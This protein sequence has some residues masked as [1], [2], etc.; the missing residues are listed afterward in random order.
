MVARW[1]PS[2]LCLVC[3]LLPP[4]LWS[5]WVPSSAKIWP[6]LAGPEKV[7]SKWYPA[8]LL[9]SPQESAERKMFLEQ[10]KRFGCSL[11]LGFC[12][13]EASA[14]F[15]GPG[16][17]QPSCPQRASLPYTRPARAERL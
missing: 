10:G 6:G 15:E 12:R 9:L 16:T 11:I 8:S 5:L 3:S 13:S 17:Q 7:V 14:A 4:S 1:F 2:T